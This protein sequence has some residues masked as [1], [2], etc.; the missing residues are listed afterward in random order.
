MV[1]VESIK[2]RDRVVHQ[3]TQHLMTLSEEKRRRFLELGQLYSASQDEDERQ[4]I[5][6]V[7]LE[8]I[9]PYAV[10]IAWPSGQIADLEDCVDEQSMRRV[11]AYRKRVGKRIRRARKAANLTQQELADKAGIPQS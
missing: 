10:G 2:N 1:T 4:E 11:E 7:A 6:H 3:V 9:A 8:I 5:L